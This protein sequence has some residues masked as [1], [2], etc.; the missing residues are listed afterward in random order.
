MQ[1]VIQNGIVDLSGESNE[2][3][4]VLRE[5]TV[6]PDGEGNDADTYTYSGSLKA[7]GEIVIGTASSDDNWLTCTF[8]K[9]DA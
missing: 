2:K 3:N 4:A 1:I 5:W 6:I 7:N 8:T 9:A